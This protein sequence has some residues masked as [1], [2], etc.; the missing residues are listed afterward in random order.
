MRRFYTEAD[1]QASDGGKVYMR[2]LIAAIVSLLFIVG[3]VRAGEIAA[4]GIAPIIDNKVVQARKAA[5]EEAKRSA[6]EQVL[7][8]YVESR[9]EVGNFALASDKIYSSVKGRIDQYTISLDEQQPGDIY[10]VEIV[11]TFEND[12]LVSAT[13]KLLKKFHWHKKPRLLIHVQ[14]EG[15]AA[16]SQ[17]ARQLQQGLEQQFRRQGFEVF[18]TRSGNRQRAGFL[19]EVATFVKTSEAEY[20]GVV[21]KGT[22]VSATASLKRI[23]AG[24]IIASAT[25][26]DSKAGGNQ[27]KAFKS[28]N[29]D[30]SRR[31]YKE[32]S[33]QLNEE[34]L[35][36][37]ARGTNII[38]ELSGENLGGRLADI[39]A[40][41]N[42]MLRG[43]QSITTDSADSEGAVLTVLYSGWPEQL[44][45]ELSAA[46][47]GRS[48][49]DMAI[50]G[51][52][53]NALQIRVL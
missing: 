28:I 46:L 8:S 15:N 26:N 51:M 20:Q 2:I 5:L 19:L 43:A 25:Y 22:E 50:E 45:D 48:N 13:E 52:N 31:L 24:E 33:W 34:W 38:L 7:G 10:R 37:Q 18:D 36:H 12:E 23:G 16:A 41:L 6:V 47:S 40:D 42:R 53:G 44:L 17:V 21:I 30:A 1:G 29:K 3:S 39:K 11:A 35:R 32:I 14:G 9:T 4:V 27:A 49:A